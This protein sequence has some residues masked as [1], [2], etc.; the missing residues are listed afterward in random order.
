MIYRFVD[1]KRLIDQK[2]KCASYFSNIG[3]YYINFV[4]T[5]CFFCYWSTGIVAGMGFPIFV[6]DHGCVSSPPNMMMHMALD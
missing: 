4:V 3:P 6:E 2:F 5:C 1:A